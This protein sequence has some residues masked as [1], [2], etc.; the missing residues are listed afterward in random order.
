VFQILCP[1]TSPP[2]SNFNST[3]PLS[4]NVHVELRSMKWYWECQRREYDGYSKG[5]SFV[6][7]SVSRAVEC[8]YV[9]RAVNVSVLFCDTVT[10]TSAQLHAAPM[11]DVAEENF[12]GLDFLLRNLHIPM[13][14]PIFPKHN[15]VRI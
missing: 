14:V 13:A 7:T 4:E 3:H 9:S 1:E 10:V 8:V 6:A 11:D 2:H 15:H 12:R 5:I